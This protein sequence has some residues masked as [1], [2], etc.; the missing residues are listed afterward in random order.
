MRLLPRLTGKIYDW[1][2]LVD[3]CAEHYIPFVFCHAVYMKEIFIGILAIPLRLFSFQQIFQTRKRFVSVTRL[4]PAGRR[5]FVIPFSDLMPGVFI[6]VT[7]D[8]QQLPVAAV[9][10]VVI[11]VVIPVMDREFPNPLA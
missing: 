8:T 10:R 5:C 1:Q 6:V 2:R 3:F 4:L 7:V 11:V 9:R